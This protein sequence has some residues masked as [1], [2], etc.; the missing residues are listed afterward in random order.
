MLVPSSS[1]IEGCRNFLGLTITPD[2]ASMI[3]QKFDK[4]YVWLSGNWSPL[5]PTVTFAA[6][7]RTKAGGADLPKGWMEPRKEVAD[8]AV[9]AGA[10]TP[11]ASDSR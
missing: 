5:G 3:M 11:K 9:A 7:R 6:A 2:D 4:G 8:A 1:V 10:P